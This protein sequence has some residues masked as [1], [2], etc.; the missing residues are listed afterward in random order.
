MR[1]L[2]ILLLAAAPLAAE[3]YA[4]LLEHAPAASG[5]PRIGIRA[6]QTSLRSQLTRRNMQVT[7]AVERILN[8]VFVEAAPDRVAE[9]RSLAG[10]RAVVPVR[11]YTLKLHRA[12][13]LVNAPAAWSALGGTANAGAGVKIAVIDT[14][15]EHTHP[16]FQDAT[17]EV[18]AGYPRCNGDD[19]RFTN[20]KIIAARSYVSLLARSDRGN[21]AETLPDDPSPRD[22]DGHGTA[23]A[24]VA[25]G[26]PNSGPAGTITGMAPKA[27]LG[28]Y[29]IFGNP[30]IHP[31]TTD[32]L[33]IMALEQALEDGMDV[34]VLS[35][36]GPA[37]TGP[38]DTGEACGLPPGVPCDVTVA[39]IENVVREGMAVVAAA[40]NE[41]DL[42]EQVPA[43]STVG[44]P[45]TAPSAISVGATTNGH[46]FVNSLRVPG[47]DVPANLRLV[48]A[49]FGDGP[50]PAEPVTAPLRDAAVVA[51]DDGLA[52]AALPPGSFTGAFALIRRGVCSFEEKALNARAAGAVGTVFY[53]SDAEEI[54]SPGGVATVGIPTA[55][56]SFEAGTALRGF[57]AGHPDHP[58][59]LNPGI[60]AMPSSDY[61]NMV[62]FSSR[63]PN[64][65][66]GEIKPEVVAVG[67][68]LYVADQT[69]NPETYT[70]DSSGYA[71][72]GGTSFSAPMA[73]G[74]VALVKQR[75]PE[76]TVPQ[77][78]SAIINTASPAVFEEGEHAGVVAAGAGK[79]D[80]AAALRTTVTV[81]P[82]TLSFGILDA[83]TPEAVTQTLVVRNAAASQVVLNLSIEPRA[84]DMPGR[85]K[86][87][88]ASLT[89]AGGASAAVEVTLHTA[90]LAPGSYGGVLAVAGGP[91]TLRVPYLYVVGDGKPHNILML[92]GD[93]YV[94][95]VAEEHG[96]A[97]KVVD[98]YGVGVPNL[99]VS[100]RVL[101][102]GG[103]VKPLQ[104]VTD[105]Y[106]IAQADVT[107][108][109]R[110]GLQEFEGSA[111]GLSM[112]FLGTA[113]YRPRIEANGVR[114]AAGLAAGQAVA[115]GSH[116]TIIGTGL[117]E[118]ERSTST[119]RLP[120]TLA[121]THVSF[122][123]PGVSVPAHLWYA[124]PDRVNLQVPW[125]LAGKESALVKV[126]YLNIKGRLATVRLA[127]YSPAVFSYTEGWTRLATAQ[128]AKENYRL[129]TPQQ[130]VPAGEVIVVYCNGLGP[131]NHRPPSGEPTPLE[132]LATTLAT[133]VV[134]V[135]GR[136][137]EV[138]FSGLTPGEVG[139]YQL[140]L[141]LPDDLPA[142]VHP[143]VVS[144]GGHFSPPV[145]LPVAPG[146]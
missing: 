66:R 142:G 103:S 22:S 111:G 21:P 49:L 117:N 7:G 120:I 97:F 133:P 61:D 8:A 16:A 23:V 55:M 106:G 134:T 93:F 78:R 17:L 73:A 31:S 72:V 62:D 94:D 52:C 9:L 63:G 35:L 115:P 136:P 64:I 79:L 33:I 37:F 38:L 10:V 116:I 68:N 139:L 29:R 137:V 25:A 30:D 54:F 14:G 112:T 41:A 99:P 91:V 26:A 85:V 123:A 6:A 46:R 60:T 88:Q 135:G 20:N 145:S 32:D 4:L 27:W 143:L 5:G 83:S 24:M 2:W 18:P 57:L 67:S 12:A 92:Y 138:L 140:N 146:V 109:P 100:F 71:V 48:H 110:P 86:L 129:I 90:N 144:I 42:A 128:Y 28:N 56:I 107:L 113:R 87:S 122:D 13:E 50:R 89:L 80:I 124:S 34:A 75:N 47:S 1:L 36:G 98:R 126:N 118:T 70:Y 105:R 96:L 125:E 102:G 43:L 15:I 81:E 95:A 101:E 131:V 3:R 74:A 130:P 119:A 141:R 44:S 84:P 19:C 59:T 104:T 76:F 65:G 39:A 77:L 69:Y 114:N 108:G 53:M 82:A 40:G 51:G 58:V 121:G 45:A 132:P 11:R 127:E